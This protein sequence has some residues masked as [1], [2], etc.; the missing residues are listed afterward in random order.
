MPLLPRRWVAAHPGLPP[1]PDPGPDERTIKPVLT[2][3][4]PLHQ[5]VSAAHIVAYLDV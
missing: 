5:T 1:K 4:E 2:T 3:E